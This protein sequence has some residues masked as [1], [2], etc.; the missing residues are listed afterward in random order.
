[1]ADEIDNPKKDQDQEYSYPDK[2]S[3]EFGDTPHTGGTESLSSLLQNKRVLAVVG[4]VIGLYILISLFS[5]DAE[6]VQDDIIDE[7]SVVI[8]QPEILV[9]QTPVMESSVSIF[10][11]IDQSTEQTDQTVEDID[12]LKR[13]IASINRQ[14][15]DFRS[16]MKQLEIKLETILKTVER[17]TQQ[18]SVLAQSQVEEKVEKKAEIVKQEYKIRAVISGRAWVEDRSGNNITVKVGDNIPTY[19]RVTKI[20][21][22]EGIIETSSGRVISFSHNE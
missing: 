11:T 9:D 22:V 1:M 4:G 5:G 15:A 10:D 12:A 2:F 17:S 13:Q 14:N 7:E 6:E 8:E 19:G 20:K 21:P 3:K 18:L 16:Q